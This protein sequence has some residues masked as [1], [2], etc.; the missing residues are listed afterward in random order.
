MALRRKS[1]LTQGISRYEIPHPNDFDS[2]QTRSRLSHE[3]IFIGLC[4]GIL[5]GLF[6]ST[7]LLAFLPLMT[8]GVTLSAQVGILLL[9]IPVGAVLGFIGT[10]GALPIVN[11]T[12]KLFSK[13]PSLRIESADNLFSYIKSQVLHTTVNS[14]L[15]NE[16]FA[17]S[18]PPPYSPRTNPRIAIANFTPPSAPPELFLT[19]NKKKGLGCFSLFFR[20][21]FENQNDVSLGLGLGVE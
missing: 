13:N 4:M 14:E 16:D 20:R 1:I 6:A 15:K 9:G 10:L 21:A 19:E 17:I 18:S 7:G 3:D 8:M 12:N 5:F 2:A 11:G